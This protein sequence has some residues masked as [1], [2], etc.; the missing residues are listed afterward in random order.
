MP[1]LNSSCYCINKT[2]RVL[3]KRYWKRF[4]LDLTAPAHLKSFTLALSLVPDLKVG[5]A[6]SQLDELN[7]MGLIG[8]QGNKGQRQGHHCYYNGQ[9]KQCL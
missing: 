9:H 8:H 5:D 4:D 2:P 6:A 7:G 1:E 3:F